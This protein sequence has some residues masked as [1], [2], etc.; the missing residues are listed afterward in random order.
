MRTR[1]PLAFLLV[2]L[3][4]TAA[5]RRPPV[6][7]WFEA[8]WFTGVSGSYA[9]W[10]DTT[11]PAKPTGAWG[12]AGPG[13]SAEWSQGGESEWNSI[14]AAAEETTAKCERPLVVP[15]AGTYRVWV[16]YVDHRHKTEPFRV[17]L[18]QPGKAAITAELGEK[19]VVPPNDEY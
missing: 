4:L 13:I 18:Q 14:G 10:P 12:I 9:Y 2:A 1:L 19:P 5:D 6:Y 7:L 17:A 16:R 15:R 11:K 3:P 8:E